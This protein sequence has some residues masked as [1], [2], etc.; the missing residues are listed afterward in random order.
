M[1]SELR[2]WLKRTRHA[3]L[4]IFT[5]LLVFSPSVIWGKLPTSTKTEQVE[6]VID[7]TETVKQAS[8]RLQQ[9]QTKARQSLNSAQP[10]MENT[11]PEQLQNQTGSQENSMMNHNNWLE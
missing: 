4:L 2:H 7:K 3:C 9:L 6:S 8:G 1:K 11:P 10:V 5:F